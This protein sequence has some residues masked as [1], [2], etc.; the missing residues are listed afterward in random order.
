MLWELVLAIGLIL[1]L[2]ARTIS[3]CRLIDDVVPMRDVLYVVPTSTPAP[4]FFKSISPLPDRLWAIGVHILNTIIMYL[5]FGGHAALLFAVFPI[6]VNNVAWITGSY[7]ST[8]TFLTLVSYYFLVHT[9]SWLG[10]PLGMVFFAAALNATLVTIAFPFVFLFDHHI[11]LV[12]LIPLFFFL[13]GSRFQTGIKIRGTFTKPKCFV[14]DTITPARAIVCL[15]VIAYY[16]YLTF[17]PMKLVFFHAFGNKFAVDGEQRRGLFSI[18][19]MFWLSLT[20]LA[21]F[22]YA[23]FLVGRGFW[24][25]WFIVM[26]SAF[27]QYKILGQFFAERYMY[28]AIVGFIGVVSAFP[29]VVIAVLFGAYLMR[30][31]MFIPVFRS[32][33]TLYENG[34]ALEP[35]E[36]SNFCNLSDWHLLVEPDLSLAGYYAQKTIE[37]DPEDFK[38]HINLSSLFMTL[39]N[40]PFALAEARKGLAKAEGRTSDQFLN[41]IVNQIQR[42]QA[43]I[44]ES[45]PQTTV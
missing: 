34:T 37:I 36:P 2:Y 5:L 27:S 9:P 13:I 45:Q 19:L 44:D 24:A 7:Y 10:V 6:C 12:T 16:L 20:L 42:I 35:T 40:Y 3:Y 15:K 8:A 23:G 31:H 11:G 1:A 28:P 41:I 30:T 14:P 29:P 22:V 43:K 33:G 38:P 26:I 39:Q 4:Q 25:I 18:N 32:N 17:V 21:L